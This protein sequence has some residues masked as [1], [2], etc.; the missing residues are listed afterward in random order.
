MEC[1]CVLLQLGTKG[2]GDPVT[3]DNAYYQSLLRKPWEN[4][5]DGMA[6]MIGAR[7]A[8]RPTGERSSAQPVPRA[9]GG[10]QETASDNP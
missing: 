9:G 3:F 4:K 2:F 6:A 8:G 10:P 5:S 7:P 1:V